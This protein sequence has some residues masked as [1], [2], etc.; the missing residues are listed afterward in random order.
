MLIY[1][2]ERK[3]INILRIGQ[4]EPSSKLCTCGYKNTDLTLADRE[5]TCPVCGTHHDRDIL[6]A[7]N[8]KRIALADL[9]LKY[10]N[11]GLGKYVELVEVLR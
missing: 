4:F 2:A 6:A 7:N 9:N 11:S 8:I 1:K 3:G 5:W 10:E